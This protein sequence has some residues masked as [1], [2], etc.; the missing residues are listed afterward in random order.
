MLKSTMYT[1]LPLFDFNGN[2]AVYLKNVTQLNM[3]AV[4]LLAAQQ[5]VKEAYG[6]KAMGEEIYSSLE[7]EN[8]LSTRDSIRKILGGRAPAGEAEKRVYGMKLGVEFISDTRNKITEDNLNRLYNMAA[9]DF[10]D[11]ENKLPKHMEELVSFINSESEMDDLAKAAAIHFYVAYVHPYFDGNGRTARLLHLWY[12]VQR[13]FPSALFV[14][15]SSYIHRTRE[16]YHKAFSL[17]EQNAGISGVTDITPFLSYFA[18]H[19]YNKIETTE[20]GNDIMGLFKGALSEG[21]VTEKEHELWNFVF[22]AYGRGEFSTKQL[23]RDFQNAA[24][25]TIRGF[26]LK[27]E[28]MGL[29]TGQKYSNKTKYRIS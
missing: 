27:F 10:V 3:S 20:L 21:R 1:Q 14:P 19:V 4:K 26:V 9:G 5:T 6:I 11:D 18:T 24:Y 12:L 2:P 8:I 17:V 22:A 29:M 23:E 7:I 16:N 13:G 25:A 15:F 28:A